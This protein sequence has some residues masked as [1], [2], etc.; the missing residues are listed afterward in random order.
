MNGN[1]RITVSVSKVDVKKHFQHLDEF[2][3]TLS[4]NL[5]LAARKASEN[6][7][8]DVRSGIGTKTTPSFVYKQWR[9]LRAKW[10]SLKKAHKDEFWIETG[11][12]YRNIKVFILAKS[13]SFINIF[14]G[15]RRSDNSDA[16]TRA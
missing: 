2:V 7:T 6:Y 9:P 16:F 3:N 13:K 10:K 1:I 15:I 5:Y 8:H 11:A 12:I 14:A 4:Q